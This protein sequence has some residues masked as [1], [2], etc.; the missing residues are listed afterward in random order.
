MDNQTIDAILS[1][2]KTIAV[3]GLS[4]KP[5]RPS[6]NV[7]GYLQSQGFRIVPVNPTIEQAL[8]EKAYPT[9]DAAQEALRA[10]G[11]RIDL[12]DV[13]RASSHVPEVVKDVIR[14]QIPAL[15]LQMGVVHEEA[16]QWARH[17]GVLTVMDHC[18]MV[19]HAAWKRGEG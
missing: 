7:A 12:V 14:L 4:E 6:S 16:A 11:S 17:A 9:L 19:E 2:T 1:R 3:V 18:L 15:W 8:G 5:G 10:E 13:F